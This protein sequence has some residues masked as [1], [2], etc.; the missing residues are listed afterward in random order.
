V[1]GQ[2]DAQ[3]YAYQQ[4][5]SG[6]VQFDSQGSSVSGQLRYEQ[7]IELGWR[8]RNCNNQRQVQSTFVYNGEGELNSTILD[9]KLTNA[10]PDN[11]PCQPTACEAATQLAKPSNPRLRLT[12][13]S[14][15]LAGPNTLLTRTTR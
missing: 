11:C 9:F 1:N 12:S 8:R 4:V 7:S 6:T 2:W 10:A 3:F 5:A 13:D 14:R 15:H